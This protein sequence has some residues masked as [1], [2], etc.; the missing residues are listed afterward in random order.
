MEY[1]K[2]IEVLRKLPERCELSADEKEA[3][4]T[5]IGLLSIGA[6]Q[7]GKIRD[8]KAKREKSVEW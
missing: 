6:T 4:S 3:L 7:M 8:K 1:E 5:A 2:A